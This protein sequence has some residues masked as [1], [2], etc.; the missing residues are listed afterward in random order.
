MR[1]DEEERAREYRTT[2]NR[3]A[4]LDRA[5]GAE[6]A[7]DKDAAKA[8]REAWEPVIAAARENA[9]GGAVPAAGDDGSP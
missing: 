1:P 6:L 8:V 3:R 5:R 4:R 2:L 7:G 9:P